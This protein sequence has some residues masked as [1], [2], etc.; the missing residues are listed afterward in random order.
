[1]YIMDIMDRKR[2]TALFLLILFIWPSLGADSRL[3]DA[4]DRMEEPSEPEESRPDEAEEAETPGEGELEEPG[5]SEEP[6]EEEDEERSI[7]GEILGGLFLH[8]MF[9]T[10]WELFGME[11]LPSQRVEYNRWPYDSFDAVGARTSWE[12]GRY[13]RGQSLVSAGTALDGGH[14]Q[15]GILRTTAHLY[16]WAFRLRYLTIIEEGAPFNANVLGFRIE[17]KS[18]S[19]EAFDSG[20]SLGYGGIL[21][22]DNW[23][24]GLEMGYNLEIYWP[25]P[26]SWQFTPLVIFAEG[27]NTVGTVS[28]AVNV[29]LKR[30]YGGFEYTWQS[31]S[32]VPFHAGMLRVGF[33][34]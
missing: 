31:F 7:L 30:W 34:Y 5:D 17:R 26:V 9:N 20:F 8:Y 28:A 19:P 1:M 10:S 12:T 16:G 27:N 18:V 4:R 23:Y 22:G 6:E 2:I 15:M 32:G 29:H 3:E 24:N 14:Y 33:W 25:R 11:A 21:L 13:V